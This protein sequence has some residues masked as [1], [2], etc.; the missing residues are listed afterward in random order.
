M[1]NRLTLALALAA[2]CLWL[3]ANAPAAQESAEVTNLP[4]LHDASDLLN[5]S[6]GLP[7]ADETEVLLRGILQQQKY[8]EGG[9]PEIGAE[10]WLERFFNWMRRQLSRIGINVGNDLSA[11]IIVAIAILLLVVIVRIIWGVL[12]RRQH[13]AADGGRGEASPQL[14]PSRLRQAA[15]D[16]AAAG[17][18]REAIRLRFLAVLGAS[19]LPFSTL[20]TNSQIIRE[21]KVEH[22]AVLRPLREL[23]LCYEDAWY[24]GQTVSAEQYMHADGLAQQMESGLELEG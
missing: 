24:G 23:V 14:T 2:V 19:R 16:A 1:A 4:P 21:M 12:G 10:T 22:P 13:A 11:V 8:V 6:P 9:T 20:M 15:E 17:E 3:A 18:L 7:P 5:S